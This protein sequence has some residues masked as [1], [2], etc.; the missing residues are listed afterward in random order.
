[1]ILKIQI[2]D[3]AWQFIPLKG[4]VTVDFN[5]GQYPPQPDIDEE[6]GEV[7]DGPVPYTHCGFD[8]ALLIKQ[9]EEEREV[10]PLITDAE[11]SII[12]NRVAYLL[13]DNGN[14]IEKIQS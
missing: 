9:M 14:T 1:M 7:V 3:T 2:S 10:F 13:D 12:F 6:L 4:P 5:G 8:S 11:Q